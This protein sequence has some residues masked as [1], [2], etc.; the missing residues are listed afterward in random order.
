MQG[1][2]GCWAAVPR[3]Q[4]RA[5]PCFPSK[6]SPP[7]GGPSTPT[8]PRAPG[9]RLIFP[10]AKPAPRATEGRRVGNPSLRADSP[11]HPP[12]GSHMKTCLTGQSSPSPLRWLW[13]S[14]AGPPQLMPPG[15]HWLWSTPHC[16]CPASPPR[17]LQ[18]AAGSVS[19]PGPTW[20]GA[21]P[22]SPLLCLVAD[23]LCAHSGAS[24]GP[25]LPLCPREP[26]LT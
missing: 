11:G 1:G 5:E 10:E 2:A 9:L 15:V 24:G 16:T 14:E 20:K 25:N 13:K 26:P 3:P 6:I 7:L 18:D 8:G 19:G 12:P 22:T 17:S 4:L 23:S 21:E